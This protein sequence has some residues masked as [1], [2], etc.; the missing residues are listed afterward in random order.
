MEPSSRRPRAQVPFDPQ[1]VLRGTLLELRPLQ[2]EDFGPLF[3][4]A[5][6]PLIWEQHPEQASHDWCVHLPSRL[7]AAPL[8]T[9]VLTSAGYPDTLGY[10]E[11][12]VDLP[13]LRTC[14]SGS[15]PGL[16]S[17]RTP[18]HGLLRPRRAPL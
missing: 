15:L 14:H 6:D 1:P 4:V 17:D 12:A 2:P 10:A 18:G 11:R 3:A 8:A 5:S 13:D 16:C 9:V 7:D